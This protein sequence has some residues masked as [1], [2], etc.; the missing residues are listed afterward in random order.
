[1]LGC[2]QKKERKNFNSENKDIESNL[3]LI[4]QEN[5]IF[6]AHIF[7][8]ILQRLVNLPWQNKIQKDITQ[9]KLEELTGLQSKIAQK[10]R[11]YDRE[12]D[13]DSKKVKQQIIEEAKQ[14]LNQEAE[15]MREQK[16]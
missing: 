5:G 3:V 8:I 4:D 11:E 2:L 6:T 9:K 16:R 14:E 12:Q 7:S 1:M 10:L 13:E 15:I